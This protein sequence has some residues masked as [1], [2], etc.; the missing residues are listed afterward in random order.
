[1]EAQDTVYQGLN[2]PFGLGILAA[3]LSLA[4]IVTVAET[5]YSGTLLPQFLLGGASVWCV[6][7]AL[8]R[9]S[10]FL[11]SVTLFLVLG[12]WVKFL[13][14]ESIGLPYLEPTGLFGGTTEQ[15]DAVL[16]ASSAGLFGL[17]VA[18]SIWIS[19]V[20]EATNPVPAF[21]TG[22]TYRL[23][24]KPLAA[25]SIVASLGL[26]Y[27]NWKFS[28][29]RIGVEPTMTLPGPL[30]AIVSFLIPW[31]I[32][33]WAGCVLY[34]AWV[35]GRIPMWVVLLIGLSEGAISGVSNL[36]RGRY[37]FHAM[38]FALGW[39]QTLSQRRSRLTAL[40]CLVLAVAALFLFVGS[41]YLV[42][43]DRLRVYPSVVGTDLGQNNPALTAQE[44]ST[45]P[46]SMATPVLPS[47]PLSDPVGTPAGITE[48]PEASDL[49][50]I[51]ARAYM[52]Q[53]VKLVIDR[54]IGL[55]AAMAVSAYPEK[56]PD[57]FI[58]GVTEKPEVRNAG[59]FE[60]I[61][62]SAYRAQE[63][64]TF[65]T[66]AGSIAILFFSG[67]YLTVFVGML[68]LSLMGL[69]VERLSLRLTSS[70]FGSAVVGVAVAN[71]ICQVN[72]PYLAA[73]L[74]TQLLLTCGAI[75]I[76]TRLMSRA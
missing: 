40:P 22:R 51:E 73:V 42:Q 5:E 63:D 2:R 15:W 61:S 6:V 41:L 27:L 12:F 69:I 75:W 30:H 10:P 59:V 54:W 47:A 62:G 19:S 26:F 38:A 68:G 37:I 43:I 18:G 32:A 11:V 49:R 55:E 33:V 4:G 53:P 60:K 64:F 48:S 74:V 28:F 7:N 76:F 16:L 35:A 52:M 72:Q 57:L 71:V 14:H 31:G 36:S 20:S 8:R 17:A 65:T 3:L 29:I 13:V 39:I 56:G 46:P 23:I 9:P 44:P 1:M 70:V 24:E 66:T 21:V 25:T 58:S 45:T 50:R 34:W 67:S